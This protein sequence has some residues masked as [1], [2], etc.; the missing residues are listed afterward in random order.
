MNGLKSTLKQKI[1]VLRLK[2]GD[3]E[4]FGYL[5]DQYVIRIRRYI[6]FR[7]S[8][9]AIAHDLTHDVFL[10]AW[11]YIVD[12]KT[13]GNLQ[14]LLYRIAYH[15]VVDHYRTKDRQ[16]IL[17]ED[18]PTEPDVS[19]EKSNDTQLDVYFLKER[20][21]R[22]KPEYQDVLLLKHVEGLSIKEIGD[23]LA[24]DA[25]NVR[26]TLHRATNALKKLYTNESNAS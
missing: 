13:I 4:A 17:I 3:T 5:Y 6:Y 14:A 7:T 12:N 16:T 8:D 10:S 25:N 2:R 19:Q 20:V 21:K 9:Q 18:L 24:K 15:K 1:A 22:L 11:E 26:V 23:V